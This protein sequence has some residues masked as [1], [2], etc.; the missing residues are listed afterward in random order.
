MKTIDFAKALVAGGHDR[1]L[2]RQD[3]EA[4][5]ARRAEDVRRPGETPEQA[6]AKY[7][8]ETDD[9]K[10]LFKASKLA[11]SDD[12]AQD[13]VKPDE[14]KPVGPASARLQ[15]MARIAAQEQRLSYQQAYT[16]LLTHPDHR[17]LA[18]RVKA[19][20]LDIQSRLKARA[21]RGRKSRGRALVNF[22]HGRPE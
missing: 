17:E 21:D 12:A 11:P 14:P 22:E 9:G 16:R 18:D 2:K 19:E 13:L 1:G 8:T 20:E 5:I 15:Q 7:M 6:F 3:F 10:L 4:E